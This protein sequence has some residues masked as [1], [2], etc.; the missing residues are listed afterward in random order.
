MLR[1]GFLLLGCFITLS[2]LPVYAD[3]SAEDLAAML[4]WWET[5]G[6][7]W[8]ELDNPDST[9]DNMMFSFLDGGRVPLKDAI[10]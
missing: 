3:D 1:K 7:Y 8:S 6:R 2:L 4:E 10:Q 9:N 5:Y